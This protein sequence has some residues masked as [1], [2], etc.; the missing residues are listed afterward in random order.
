MNDIVT[1]AI[2]TYVPLFVAAVVGFLA[3]QGVILDDGASAGL[4][5]FLSSLA[6]AIYY[7]VVR[8]IAKRFPWVE[9]FLG[10]SKAP[11]GFAKPEAK[12]VAD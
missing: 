2:R 3:D 4:V 9:K 7:V 1:G 8:L 6:G 10:S 12:H 11:V 5:L